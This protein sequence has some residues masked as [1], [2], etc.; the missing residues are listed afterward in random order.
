MQYFQTGRGHHGNK[1]INKAETRNDA[2]AKSTS[3]KESMFISFV[4][5]Q[6]WYPAYG[7]LGALTSLAGIL[8]PVSMA[9]SNFRPFDIGLVMSV[10]NIGALLSP[11]WGRLADR[12]RRYRAIFSLGF[13]LVGVSFTAFC[14]TKGLGPWLVIALSQG[15]GVA[16]TTT[17][18]SLLVVIS[19]SRSALDKHIGRLQSYN[20]AGQVAGLAL[21]GVLSSTRGL[22]LAVAL[23]LPAIF[24]ALQVGDFPD[25][26]FTARTTTALSPLTRLV[27]QTELFARAPLHE[28]DARML[29]SNLRQLALSRFGR[30]LTAWFFL[31][32]ATSGFFALYPVMMP[33]VYGISAQVIAQLYAVSILVTLPLYHVVGAWSQRL[34][35]GR[36]LRIGAAAR[37]GAFLALGLL[38]FASFP[39]ASPLVLASFAALQGLWPLL[40]VSS[41][42][43]SA[44]LS[45]LGEGAGIGAFNGVGA[46][47]AALGA[48]VGGI[49]AGR[50]GYWSIP[51]LGAAGGALCWL[52]SGRLITQHSLS[53]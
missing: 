1:M 28:L 31:T 26:S 27:H 9:E 33:R 21:A 51:F 7:I 6:T 17:I 39:A 16:A 18:A 22:E 29:V 52:L 43:L 3:A 5:A 25:H 47:A 30:F 44:R 19:N 2:L 8:L 49:C 40:S 41:I 35:A 4:R 15:I 37:T 34:G 10:L 42:D 50:L 53:R 24:L 23:S 48:T 14:L 36:M 45:T 12:T 32:V 20:T 38:A 11:I 13:V 46:L